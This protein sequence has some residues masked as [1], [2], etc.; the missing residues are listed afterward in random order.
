MVTSDTSGRRMLFTS[1]RHL[2][3]LSGRLAAATLTLNYGTVVE[4]SEMCEVRGLLWARREE[5]GTLT[6]AAYASASAPRCPQSPRAQVPT[7]SRR[8]MLPVQVGI[9]CLSIFCS[10]T[11]TSSSKDC[12]EPVGWL[13]M[14]SRRCCYRGRGGTRRHA[15]YLQGQEILHRVLSS[16]RVQQSGRCAERCYLDS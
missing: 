13:P 15:D 16:Y 7:R 6:A 11:S 12:E 4:L 1:S 5:T 3:K 10:Q 14:V 8:R 2:A 9:G